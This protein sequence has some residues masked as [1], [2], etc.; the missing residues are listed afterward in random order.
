MVIT[1]EV[2]NTFSG[3][4]FEPKL[5]VKIWCTWS[6]E[7]QIE[8][9]GCVTLQS[10]GYNYTTSICCKTTDTALVHRMVCLFTTQLSLVLITLTHRGMARVS[11]PGYIHVVE[12]NQAGGC[13]CM[14][15]Q[16][17]GEQAE[18]EGSR[19]WIHAVMAWTTWYRVCRTNVQLVWTMISACA[20][21]LSYLMTVYCLSTGDSYIKLSLIEHILKALC[22]NMAMR[23]YESFF[24]RPNW[25]MGTSRKF[26]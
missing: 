20:S 22:E 18:D 2:V 1:W 14:M 12:M 7:D 15:Y 25:F 19:Q 9:R 3:S 23:Q 17:S 10:V 4:M 24:L 6:C 5:H 8:P 16:G 21:H 26:M 11:W 13:C